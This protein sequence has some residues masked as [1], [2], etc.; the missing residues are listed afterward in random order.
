MLGQ[1][2]SEVINIG[3]LGTGQT[4]NRM[5]DV[6]NREIASLP[7]RRVALAVIAYCQPRDKV[8]QA[9]KI[10]A[11]VS[12]K[13]RF[14][15]DP[16]GVELLHSPSY[17]LNEIAT[18][19]YVQADCDDVAILTAALAKAVGLTCRFVAV[20]FHG[21]DGYMHVYTDIAVGGGRWLTVDPTRP[22]TSVA[23]ID[24]RMVLEV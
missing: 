10:A 3:S 5:R 17:L 4:L 16:T 2:T 22:A 18:H 6:A 7:V 19:Y 11:F 24:Q 15:P 1:S 9:R 23:V 8:C 20:S 14:A 21:L 12:T 13:I